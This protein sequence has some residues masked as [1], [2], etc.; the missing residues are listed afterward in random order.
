MNDIISQLREYLSSLDNCEFHIQESDTVTHTVDKYTIHMVIKH[1]KVIFDWHTLV[2]V[3][4]HEFAH[5]IDKYATESHGP[6]FYKE[7]MKLEIRATSIYGYRPD[8]PIDP[9]YTIVEI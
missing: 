7:K 1:K 2:T 5:V 4:I 3:A 6:S 8:F 9:D